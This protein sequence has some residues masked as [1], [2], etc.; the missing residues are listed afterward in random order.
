MH[1]AIYQAI[2]AR[3]RARAQRLMCEHL[4]QA[5]REHEDERQQKDQEATSPSTEEIPLSRR[6]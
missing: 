5:E 2:R 4:L 3:D 6:R 1:R